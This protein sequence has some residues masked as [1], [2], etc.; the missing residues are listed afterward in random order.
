[1]GMDE[2]T[3]DVPTRRDTLKYGATLATGVSLAGCS[4]L[5]DQSKQ[6]ETSGSD[7]YSVSMEPMGSVTFET[8]PERWVAYDGGY[9]DM[10]SH[11]G[12]LM[13]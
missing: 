2:T 5:A 6:G 4:E 13:D 12:K 8:V 3:H 1:M 9:A 7:S 10:P 11:W